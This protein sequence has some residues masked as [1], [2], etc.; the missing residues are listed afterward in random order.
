MIFNTEILDTYLTEKSLEGMKNHWIF[1]SIVEGEYLIEEPK[2][3][4]EH[5][6]KDVYR[7]LIEKLQNFEP[8]NKCLWQQFFGNIKVPDTIC[9]YLIVGSPDPYDAMV[10]KDAEGNNCII[11]D[12]VRISSYA[13]DITKLSDIVSNFITHEMAHILIGD[14]YPYPSIEASLFDNLKHIVFDE[15]IAHFLAFK[16]D[17]LSFDWYSDEMNI[18]RKKS[19]ETLVSILKKDSNSDKKQI[20]EKSN[21]GLFWEKFGSISGLF[22]IVDYYNCNNKDIKVFKHIFEKGPDLLIAFIL[23]SISI[24]S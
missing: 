23:N 10:R 19:Y 6:L 22:A 11:I 5:K 15:G 4:D 7:I 20:L 12:L 3:V 14:M 8:L 17:V 16:D 2:D 18:R 24:D 9:I 1:N 13:E 21:S